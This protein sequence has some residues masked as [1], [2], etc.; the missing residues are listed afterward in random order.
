MSDLNIDPKKVL[1]VFGGRM[2]TW[3]RLEKSGFRLSVKTIEKWVERNN[4]PAH[5][6][7]QVAAC[8][9]EDGRPIDLYNLVVG[10]TPATARQAQN[11]N[12]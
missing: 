7:A 6:I 3:R 1:A 12:Q 8:A 5:R 9:K 4:I 11:N 10:Q 2:G